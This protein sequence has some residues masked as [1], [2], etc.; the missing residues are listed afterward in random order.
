MDFTK[1][2]ERKPTFLRA[3]FKCAEYYDTP[4]DFAHNIDVKKDS[5]AHTLNVWTG[6]DAEGFVVHNASVIWAI[7]PKVRIV[8]V[9]DW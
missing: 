3:L 9:V 6:D 4:A 8:L 2:L 7:S 5:R 1:Q